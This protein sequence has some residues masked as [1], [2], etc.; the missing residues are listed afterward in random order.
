MAS[1]EEEKKRKLPQ[2]NTAFSHVVKK[3]KESPIAKAAFSTDPSVAPAI[4]PSISMA[5]P[6][7]QPM[8]PPVQESRMP[9]TAAA[10]VLNQ[11]DALMANRKAMADNSRASVQ[12][13]QDF[14]GKTSEP[15]RSPNTVQAL[16]GG[17]SRNMAFD[18]PKGRGLIEEHWGPNFNTKDPGQS[19]YKGETGE[20][21]GSKRDAIAGEHSKDALAR[22]KTM[23]DLEDVRSEAARRSA[24]TEADK[25][26]IA[27][28]RDIFNRGS[29]EMMVVQDDMG[30][31]QVVPRYPT[32]APGYNAPV[33][34]APPEFEEYVARRRQNPQAAAEYYD[35]LPNDVKARML[36]YLK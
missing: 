14:M 31:Q 32:E 9:D 29:N 7:R 1:P 27:L 20:W 3:V 5:S 34:S 6:V 36:Q 12:Y 2:Y 22:M 24:Q 26:K 21:F 30:Q 8:A 33:D 25:A 23:A 28:E 18:Q 17:Q 35:S 4:D 15:S 11:Q 19:F 13:L 10:R 16:S